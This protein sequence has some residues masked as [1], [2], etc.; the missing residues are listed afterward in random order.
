MEECLALGTSSLRSPTSA[1][2]LWGETKSFLTPISSFLSI[3]EGVLLDER[4]MKKEGEMACEVEGERSEERQE[5]EIGKFSVKVQG[6]E[7]MALRLV[8]RWKAHKDAISHGL[9]VG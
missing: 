1:C 8:R 2:T 6:E 3:F 4:G 5:N 7:K 9:L